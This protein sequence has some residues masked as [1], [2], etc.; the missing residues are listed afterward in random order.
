MA[1]GILITALTS[2]YLNMLEFTSTYWAK[3]MYSHG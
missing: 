2:G 3:D 1:F